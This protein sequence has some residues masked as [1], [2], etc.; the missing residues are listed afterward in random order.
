VCTSTYLSDKHFPL[1][2]FAF[3]DDEFGA[4]QPKRFQNEY[5]SAEPNPEHDPNR[6]QRNKLYLD[7][8]FYQGEKFLDILHGLSPLVTRYYRCFCLQTRS[9]GG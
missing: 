6:P 9:N 3:L 2:F 4:S 5:G 8:H 1:F 7:G